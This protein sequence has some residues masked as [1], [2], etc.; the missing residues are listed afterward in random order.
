MTRCLV[1]LVGPLVAFASGDAGHHDVRPGFTSRTPVETQNEH[2]IQN[3]DLEL[4][5]LESLIDSK[6]IRYFQL[7]LPLS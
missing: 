2:Y 6:R 5:R 4:F 3:E 1:E 7:A